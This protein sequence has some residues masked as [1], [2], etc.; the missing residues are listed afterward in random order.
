MQ[1][2]HQRK[3]YLAQARIL[4]AADGLNHGIGYHRLVLYDHL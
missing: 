4:G 3:Q 1:M 2:S